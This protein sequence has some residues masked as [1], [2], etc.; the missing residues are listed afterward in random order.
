MIIYKTRNPESN[1]NFS[2][3]TAFEVFEENALSSTTSSTFQ[4]KLTATTMSDV[5]GKYIIQWFAEIANSSNNNQTLMRVEYK[6]TTSGTWTIL[7][8]V[9]AFIGRSEI[10][11]GQTGFRVIELLTNDTIDIRISFAAG[12]ATARIRNVNTYVFRVEIT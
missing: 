12:G 2:N 5:S 11:D 9:D 8:D 3:A 6:P 7:S 10:Y 1:F 4:T